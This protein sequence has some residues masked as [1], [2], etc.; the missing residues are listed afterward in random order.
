MK[1]TVKLLSALSVMFLL[2]LGACDNGTTSSSGDDSLEAKVQRFANYMDK[3]ITN[4]GYAMSGVEADVVKLYHADESGSEIFARIT[5]AERNPKRTVTIDKG[6]RLLLNTT[7]EALTFKAEDTVGDG[8]GTATFTITGGG[9]LELA[10]ASSLDIVGPVKIIIDPSVTLKLSANL[11]FTDNVNSD[12]FKLNEGAKIGIGASGVVEADFNHIAL[13]SDGVHLSLSTGGATAV[14]WAGVDSLTKLLSVTVGNNASFEPGSAGLAY[15]IGPVT[16]NRGGIFAP[17]AD[18]DGTL[19]SVTVNSGGHYDPVGIVSTEKVTLND[20][21]KSAPADNQNIK[22]LTVNAGAELL[23]NDSAA[24]V[25]ISVS[26]KLVNNG[27]I[28]VDNANA[29]TLTVSGEFNNTGT[30]EVKY[31]GSEIQVKT[32]KGV[33]SNKGK[34]TFSAAGVLAISNKG[35][36][37]N[38]NG[39]SINLN[40]VGILSITSGDD[41]SARLILASG[42]ILEGIKLLATGAGDIIEWDSTE[43]ASTDGTFVFGDNEAE[44][45]NPWKGRP[46]GPQA[47]TDEDDAA[48]IRGFVKPTGTVTITADSAGAVYAPANALVFTFSE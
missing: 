21:A 6:V 37:R 7:H 39:G 30:V 16:V 12:N 45:L 11:C 42:S 1:K 32:V 14:V 24:A 48:G 25:V 20:G 40:V 41:D 22:E 33:L 44:R 9:T 18:F 5:S 43:L 10:G 34:I 23:V 15:E 38:E 26:D 47:F 27:K 8:E 3:V 31:D 2:G 36:V 19:Q 46:S 28:V 29:S 4:G 13:P 35:T 17:S